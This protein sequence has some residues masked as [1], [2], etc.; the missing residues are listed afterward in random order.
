MNKLAKLSL[1]VSLAVTS[2]TSL[3]KSNVVDVVIEIPKSQSIQVVSPTD[4]DLYSQSGEAICIDNDTIANA[5]CF[6]VTAKHGEMALSSQSDSVRFQGVSLK[7]YGYTSEQLA[8]ILSKSGKVKAHPVYETKEQSVRKNLFYDSATPSSKDLDG[9]DWARYPHFESQQSNGA[10]SSVYDAWKFYGGN[11]VKSEEDTIDVVVLDSGFHIQDDYEFEQG[12]N[13]MI[14]KEYNDD[15]SY[16][17]V[18]GYNNNF[19]TDDTFCTHGMQTASIIGA[20]HN[21]FGVT[22]VTQRA[23]LYAGRVM[24]C[25][26]GNSISLADAILWASGYFDDMSSNPNQTIEPYR[27]RVGVINMSIGGTAPC[28][29]YLQDAVDKAYEKGWIL[30]ASAGNESHET[31]RSF[32]ANCDHVVSVG[33]VMD[34]RNLIDPNDPDFPTGINKA[35][36]EREYYSNYGRETDVF[37][38]GRNSYYSSL[39]IPGNGLSMG[40]SFS[41]PLVAGILAMAKS[42]TKADNDQL[43]DNLKR[44]A[45]NEDSLQNGR[46]QVVNGLGLEEYVCSN[47]VVDA[48]RLIRLTLLQQEKGT[49]NY[50]VNYVNELDEVTEKMLNALPEKKAEMCETY[51][52]IYDAGARKRKHIYTLYRFE[53]GVDVNNANLELVGEFDKNSPMIRMPDFDNYQYA[54]KW[55]RYDTGDET[56]PDGGEPI[57]TEIEVFDVEQAQKPSI[58]Q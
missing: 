14:T 54:G 53:K 5:W 8:K 1:L 25:G 20:R 34:G 7:S 16:N 18:E 27:G 21:G 10:G 44:T 37:A 17:V 6:S 19:Y 2:G 39:G 33:A 38:S 50:V 28:P 47:G 23:K 41:S 43:I 29:A 26:K 57:C 36:F 46:C 4:G 45:T 56:N 48:E 15:G 9:M 11:E 32:P 58:C 49:S 22:G 42:V 55:C 30:V 52:F 31:Y 40:T 24:E 12:A 35:R 51:A 13:F 3:A